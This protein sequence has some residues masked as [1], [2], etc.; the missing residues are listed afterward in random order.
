M[1]RKGYLSDIKEAFQISPVLAIL[2]PRQCGK[3]TLARE[4]F[5]SVSGEK[6]NYLD[7]ESDLDVVRLENPMLGLGDLQG[8]I[9]IDEIQRAPDIF[10]ALR[11]LVDKKLD[12]LYLI[13][14]SASRDLIRQSSETFAG[15]I[16]YMELTPFHAREVSDIKILWERGGLPP[17]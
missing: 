15:R 11:V 17:S 4:Y 5:S 14:G 6:Q 13:L 16:T 10:K 12:Q 2:G 9:V 1:E 7:L 8:L 3:T